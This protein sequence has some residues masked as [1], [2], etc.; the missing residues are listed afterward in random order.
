MAL[1]VEV[2]EVD[3]RDDAQARWRSFIEVGCR[4]TTSPSER[5]VSGSSCRTKTGSTEAV[6]SVS[7]EEK[8]DHEQESGLTPEKLKE[9]TS[10]VNNFCGGSVL[11]AH[12]VCLK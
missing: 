3:A 5:K 2:G 6:S 4:G 7:Q 1:L 12:P 11:D 10:A 9:K 8:P